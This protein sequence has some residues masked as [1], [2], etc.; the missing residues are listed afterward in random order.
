MMRLLL[1]AALA[2]TLAFAQTAA[3]EDSSDPALAST[4]AQFQSDLEG[5]TSVLAT[6]ALLH[7][8]TGAYPRT[9]FG[10]LGSQPAS[11]TGLRMRSLS[12]M[13]VTPTSDGVTIRYVPLPVAP[14]VRRD[15]VVEMSVVLEDG[16]YSADYEILQREDPDD[17][18]DQIAYDR[19]GRYLVTRGFGTACVDLEV[20]RERLAEGTFQPE[21]GTLGRESLTVRVHPVG[22]PSPVFYQE[23]R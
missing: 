13:S 9:T 12:E 18:G 7:G 15:R 23:V 17:G 11:R 16:L 3:L 22:S 8:E 14:Y 2:P 5:V 19:A 4:S 21:P 6:V 20:V 10:L 1:L